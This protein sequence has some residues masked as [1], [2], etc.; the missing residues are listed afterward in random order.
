MD[1][2]GTSA[3]RR[4]T[5][6]GVRGMISAVGAAGLIAATA[7][8]GFGLAGVRS[9]GDT[10]AD[11]AAL[12]GAL[13]H[14]QEIEYFNADVSG[15]QTAY[16]WDARLSGPV[17][18]VQPDAANRAGFLD[19]ADGLRTELTAMPVDALMSSLAE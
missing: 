11:V 6:L 1:T 8:G 5:R 18:A 14:T 3:S 7:V 12:Q 19:V 13:S 10:R 4:R 9:A 2:T 16:A 17:A 15:W